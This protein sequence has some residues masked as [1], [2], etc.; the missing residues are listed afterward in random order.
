MSK[1][2]TVCLHV[3]MTKHKR[4]LA[5]GTL[6]SNTQS[7]RQIR[8]SSD[9]FALSHLSSVPCVPW[10][11]GKKSVTCRKTP[12]NKTVKTV[13]IVHARL[14]SFTLTSQQRMQL[15]TSY[16]PVTRNIRSVIFVI[17][18]QGSASR[19]ARRWL[20]ESKEQRV[21][22]SVKV[23]VSHPFCFI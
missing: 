18:A 23:I 20:C 2:Y 8:T 11:L 3:V 15:F 1:F 21:T 7:S 13:V 10:T 6:W 16:G 5:G 9:L 19:D 4:S 22:N 14:W 17:A 12:N